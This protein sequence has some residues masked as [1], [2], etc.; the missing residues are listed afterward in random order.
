VGLPLERSA[1]CHCS[2]R[3]P[4]HPLVVDQGRGRYRYAVALEART[5]SRCWHVRHQSRP[6]QPVPSAPGTQSRARF[7]VDYRTEREVRFEGSRSWRSW[8]NLRGP[9]SHEHSGVEILEVLLCGAKSAASKFAP[10][11]VSASACRSRRRG[12]LNGPPS[13]GL[14]GKNLSDTL[15]ELP[16]SAFSYGQRHPT[17]RNRK[18]STCGEVRVKRAALKLAGDRQAC[19]SSRATP[20]GPHQEPLRRH[21]PQP[22][23]YARFRTFPISSANSPRG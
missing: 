7:F 17:R 4:S 21:R 23:L 18:R 15:T 19:R 20:H 8:V 3:P 14:T 5:S 6:Q 1:R 13:E 2:V 10:V 22:W 9:K 11:R 16:R 12:P